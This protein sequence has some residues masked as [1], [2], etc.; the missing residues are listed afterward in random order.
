MLRKSLT[1][2]TP[3]TPR[4]IYTV[5]RG[6]FWHADTTTI[7][8]IL[9]LASLVYATGLMLPGV[10]LSQPNFAIMRQTMCKEGWALLF[11]LHWLGMSWRFLDPKPRVGWAL[12]INSFGLLVWT[13]S[14]FTINRSYPVYAP[15][16]SLEI[17]VCLFSA[18]ALLRTGLKKEI[19]NP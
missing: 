16:T 12:F 15:G 1:G 7:R 11:F 4:Y 19:L 3:Y 10:D 2:L 9:A 13:V 6:L 18:W 14:T 8:L 5:C 17:V